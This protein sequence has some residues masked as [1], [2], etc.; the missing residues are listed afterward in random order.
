M[1]E[2]LIFHHYMRTTQLFDSKILSLE[3]GH[4][5]VDTLGFYLC[6]SSYKAWFHNV[7][8]LIYKIQKKNKTRYSTHI[9]V[10]IFEQYIQVKITYKFGKFI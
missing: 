9:S 1:T 2:L 3:I 10:D 8:A 4:R 5:S 7:S 6:N